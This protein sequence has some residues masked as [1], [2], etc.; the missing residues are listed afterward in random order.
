MVRHT[1]FEF[2]TPDEPGKE[3]RDEPAI[4]KDKNGS[5]RLVQ[6]RNHPRI[7]QHSKVHLQAWRANGDTIHFSHSV[8]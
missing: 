2:G 4:L 8:F 1:R 3:L 6:A 5:T 7:V